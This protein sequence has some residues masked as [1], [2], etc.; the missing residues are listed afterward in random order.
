[1]KSSAS[2]TDLT[3]FFLR[4]IWAHVK[5][6]KHD[7]NSV[8][9]LLFIL[10][11]LL[12]RSENKTGSPERPL[13]DLGLISYRSYWTEIVLGFMNN[14]EDSA[15]SIKGK[16]S[17]AFSWLTTSCNHV[18]VHSRARGDK[19]WWFKK[20]KYCSQQRYS[21]HENRNLQIAKLRVY[22]DDRVVAL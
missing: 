1:M 6:R 12:S 8:Y 15:I 13:S 14:N 19:A 22:T 4:T 2:E 9:I 5:H 7:I 3:L 20:E 21:K 16:Y 10:G 18:S 17:P 11:Y